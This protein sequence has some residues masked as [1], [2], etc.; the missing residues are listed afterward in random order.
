MQDDKN[1]KYKFVNKQLLSQKTASYWGRTKSVFIVFLII[2]LV[3]IFRLFWIQFVNKKFYVQQSVLR[4][5]RVLSVPSHRGNIFD[6]NGQA[7]AVS[8]KV[9]A[10]WLN[11]QQFTEFNKLPQLSKIIGVSV[12]DLNK[13]I[14]KNKNKKFVYIKKGITEEQEQTIEKL[15]INEISLVP[16][17]KRYYPYADSAAQVLGFTD[18]DDHG[19]DGVEYANDAILL[20]H[21]VYNRVVKD[22]LGN[23][24]Y[25]ENLSLNDSNGHDLFL[26]IDIRLQYLAFKVLKSFVDQY[27]ADGGSVVMLDAKNGNVLA[28]ANYPSYNPNNKVGVSFSQMRNRAITDIYEPGSTIKPLIVAKALD[29][30]IVSLNTV[31]DTRPYTVGTKLIKDFD[32][33]SS[34][35]VRDIIVHS[36]DVGMTKIV[37]KFRYEDLWKYFKSL[38][39]GQKVHTKFPGEAGGLVLNW[40]R[41]TPQDAASMS[42]GYAIAVSLLQ[43]ARAYTIFTNHG[44]LLPVSFY[45]NLDNKPVKCTQVISSGTAL[46]ISKVLAEVTDRGTGRKSQLDSYEVAGKTGTAHKIGKYGY[47]K[48][49]YISSFVGF[50]PASDPKVIIAIMIDNAKGSYTGGL[51]AAPIFNAIATVAMQALVVQPDKHV[52]H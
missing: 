45:K 41:W 42:F 32:Y 17:Y 30:S 18:I 4:T 12:T 34:L 46:D 24:I 35:S 36:S 7:L 3:I 11:C 28:M 49:K 22:L 9:Y 16:D 39:F 29:S 50:V 26:S 25:T 21:N 19:I 6:T 15:K 52:I 38:G 13:L 33:F 23:V 44:C 40:Q 14:N 20:P 51:V 47:E 10:L 2:V 1:Q 8:V 37:S 48:N 43:M 31:F 27:K 5:N